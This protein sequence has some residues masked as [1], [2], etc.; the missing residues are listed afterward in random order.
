ME[1]SP[2]SFQFTSS[3]F[4]NSPPS[5]FPTF[6]PLPIFPILPHLPIFPICN[7]QLMVS[8]TCLVKNL[9][10][11]KVLFSGMRAS[12]TSQA[13]QAFLFFEVKFTLLWQL[14][15][16]CP[17]TN[18]GDSQN[19]F[20]LYSPKV[21]PNNPLTSKWTYINRLVWQK[22]FVG[23]A[24]RPK[25]YC[26]RLFFNIALSCLFFEKFCWVSMWW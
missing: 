24:S 6:S 22:L 7:S 16:K 17:W 9:V 15:N 25:F 2:R 13:F 3:I 12:Q 23:T 21:T 10:W 8:W 14:D 4:P 20:E 19:I 1:K 18:E 26:F 5:I 11:K